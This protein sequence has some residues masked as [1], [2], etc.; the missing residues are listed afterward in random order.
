MATTP[1]RRRP[2]AGA[3]PP[4]WRARARTEP[5][6]WS[7]RADSGLASLPETGAP[8]REPDVTERIPRYQAESLATPERT[9]FW[10]KS[11]PAPST[12]SAPADLRPP[13]VPRAEEPTVTR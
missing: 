11:A 12:P 4:P 13:S 5:T 9:D 7:A 8:T 2:A 1:A 10:A 6:S 3:D